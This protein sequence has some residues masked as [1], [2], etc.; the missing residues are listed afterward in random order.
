M[1]KIRLPDQIHLCDYTFW[2]IPSNEEDKEYLRQIEETREIPEEGKVPA[3]KQLLEW[4][5]VFAFYISLLPRKYLSQCLFQ[6][7][8]YFTREEAFK[9]F[10]MKTSF[11]RNTVVFQCRPY[12]DW[13]PEAK[14]LVAN[15]GIAH[16]VSE[17]LRDM[18][19]SKEEEFAKE[20][21]TEKN[22]EDRVLWAMLKNAKVQFYSGAGVYELAYTPVTQ[23]EGFEN[24]E[25][26]VGVECVYE[27]L[28][29]QQFVILT[30]EFEVEGV[31]VGGLQSYFC[32][33]MIPNSP[34]K[35]WTGLKF[36]FN[37]RKLGRHDIENALLQYAPH[38][39]NEVAVL[40]KPSPAVAPQK[41]PGSSGI[42]YRPSYK[43]TSRF[44]TTPS[45]LE[46]FG[47]LLL[48]QGKL[49]L[50]Y[51]P[52]SNYGR[53]ELA[54]SEFYPICNTCSSIDHVDGYCRVPTCTRCNTRGH[55]RENCKLEAGCHKCGKTDHF[56]AECPLQVC[57][58]CEGFGHS[59]ILCP[60]LV[61][62]NCLGKGL[63]HLTNRCPNPPKCQNCGEEGHLKRDCES[64]TCFRCDSVGH[65][66]GE[67]PENAP[68]SGSA[69]ASNS[70]QSG[71]I[72]A[73]SSRVSESTA[74][75]S[76]RVE[77]VIESD[78]SACSEL[79][80]PLSP[81]FVYRYRS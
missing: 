37:I 46:V 78:E 59:C 9:V 1:T 30:D 74:A 19:V 63:G 33:P 69:S 6:L 12:C 41:R 72:S 14:E 23:I 21:E 71:N 80:E 67:C 16:Q 38:A 45:K 32:V 40:G 34:E 70:Q 49:P 61:C 25:E 64:V 65:M 76:S 39:F 55:V 7:S 26:F 73:K 68:S 48:D 58:N 27:F 81:T 75:T 28:N 51:V 3:S 53:M 62:Y 57:K 44:E 42:M 47:V 29:V 56:V 13:S 8:K 79:D 66:S 15:G 52:T 36:T 24:I 17:Q 50:S 18:S 4:S 77:I 5:V 31:T 22:L 54:C 43:P 10:H 2:P 11:V 35:V 60:E 20:G